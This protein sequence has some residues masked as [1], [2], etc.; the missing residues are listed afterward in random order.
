MLR[1]LSVLALLGSACLLCS[2]NTGPDAATKNLV[3]EAYVNAKI[4]DERAQSDF[5][6]FT[7]DDLISYINTEAVL[8]EQLDRA[9]N[10]E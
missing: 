7:D 4:I 2:C 6:S 1:K 9:I 3:R 10:P 5:E 8:W